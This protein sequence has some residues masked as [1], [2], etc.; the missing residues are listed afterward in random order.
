MAVASDTQGR[1]F[2]L[3][4]FRKRVDPYDGAQEIVRHYKMYKPSIVRI[5]TTGFQQMLKSYLTR[6]PEVDVWMPI[7]EEKPIRKKL[8]EGSRIED[9]QPLWRT[10]K[11]FVQ[12][13]MRSMLDEFIFYPKPD[14]DDLMDGV[15]YATTRLLR[16]GHKVE[17]YS[18]EKKARQKSFDWATA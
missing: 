11:F 14:H 8:G 9:L 16:P 5:E 15:Y 13:G 1:V 10:G 17:L 4:Y 18:E 2:V 6:S 12:P 7:V 3:P